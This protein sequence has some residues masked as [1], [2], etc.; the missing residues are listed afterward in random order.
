MQI[1]VRMV[2]STSGIFFLFDKPADKYIFCIAIILLNHS[3]LTIMDD[4]QKIPFKR[5]TDMDYSSMIGE[6]F[7]YANSVLTVRNVEINL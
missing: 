6:S 4:S 3:F 5:F 7:E 1:G 2:L